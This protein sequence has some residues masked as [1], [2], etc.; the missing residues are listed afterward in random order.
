M[1]EKTI[2]KIVNNIEEAKKYT[3]NVELLSLLDLE[4]DLLLKLKNE[5]LAVNRSEN[6]LK[7]IKSEKISDFIKKNILMVN[8][9]E[10]K[11]AR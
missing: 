3:E 11:P 5:G 8:V 7:I 6:D 1:D 2:K 10:N 4:K 9:N